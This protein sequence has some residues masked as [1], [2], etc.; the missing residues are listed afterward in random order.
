[1]RRLP[2]IPARDPRHRTAALALY[3]ALLRSAGKIPL[4][5]DVQ[6]AA[7]GVVGQLVRKRFAGNHAYTSLRLVYA[8]MAAGYNFLTL[9]AR[10]QAPGSPEH[11]QIVDHIRTRLSSASAARAAHPPPRKP[12]SEPYAEP[13][14]TNT[15]PPGQPPVYTSSVLPRPQSALPGDRPRRV[16]SLCITADGQPFLRIKK[17]QPRALSRMVGRKGRV[18][19][20]KIYRIVDIDEE[21]VPSAVL[22]DEWDRL[23]A[24]Q[25]RR[26]EGR[27]GEGEGDGGGPK[28]TFGWSVQLARLWWEWRVEKTWQDWTAR[29]TALNELVE[30]ER[31]LAEQEKAGSAKPG[32]RDAAQD[33]Q[34]PTRPRDGIRP[35]VAEYSAPPLPLL[36]TITTKLGRDALVE[37]GK[38]PFVSPSWAALVEAEQPRLMKWLARGAAGRNGSTAES[39]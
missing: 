8:S 32:R 20:R 23:V 33:Q 17:P 12:P 37:D 35:N 38:D 13:L 11:A 28:S 1:M 34:R 24:G 29:G 5:K 26:E 6:S 39:G 10:A 16:P 19:Q 36:S 2:F 7:P 9:F 14:I 21:L 27:A 30:Q 18:F 3:R 22:E 4:P 25:I 31:A 15:A